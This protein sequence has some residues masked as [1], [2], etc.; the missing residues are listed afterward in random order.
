MPYVDVKVI[1]DVFTPEQ[2]HQLIER[3]TDA[4]IDLEGEAM[5]EST[6][7]T[8]SEVRSGDWGFGGRSTTTEDVEAR[9]AGAS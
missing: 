2:K 6:V 3:V 1:E 5:R 4:F 8:V 7:V 9:I